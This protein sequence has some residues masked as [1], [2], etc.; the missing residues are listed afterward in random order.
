[1]VMLGVDL[2]LARTGL[3]VCDAEEILATPLPQLDCKGQ[4]LPRIAERIAQVAKERDAAQIVLGNPKALDGGTSPMS[5][6]CAAFAK[7]L[8]EASALP[9]VLR[10]ERFSSRMA[11]GLLRDAQVFGAQR[12]SVSDSAAATVIL[13]EHISSMNN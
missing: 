8:A 3:A 13:Q 12:K 7:M 10:D 2:G 6:R 4:K 1:M 9:V 11:E 5:Q